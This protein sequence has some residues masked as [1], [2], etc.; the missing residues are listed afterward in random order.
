MAY[1]LDE[2]RDG[3]ILSHDFS[4]TNHDF[5]YET[6]SGFLAKLKTQE[7]GQIV[8]DYLK[9]TTNITQIDVRRC[10]WFPNSSICGMVLL[11]NQGIATIYVNDKLNE[12]WQRFTICK[13]LMQ[14]Y[15]DGQAESEAS[16]YAGNEI[17]KQI[18]DL[19]ETQENLLNTSNSTFSNS[20][21]T[22][23]VSSEMKAVAMAM[24]LIFPIRY[25]T[26]LS[27]IPELLS[28][29]EIKAFDVASVF[30]MPEYVINAYYA[31]FNNISTDLA[32]N[33]AK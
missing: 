2:V 8:L 25:R 15:I 13:E 3:I 32:E 22:D 19:V 27:V 31:I 16:I 29:Q 30:K 12:C 23:K 20:P 18:K 5:I 33:R 28:T 21:F 14:L 11:N 10:S 9:K 17:V 7:I 4:D 1:L 26:H 6:D 24:D